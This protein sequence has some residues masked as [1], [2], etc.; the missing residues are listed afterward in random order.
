MGEMYVVGYLSHT[1][2]YHLWICISCI[3]VLFRRKES[4][5]L[6][7][8]KQKGSVP[9]RQVMLWAGFDPA[10]EDFL[11]GLQPTVSKTL[12][13]F[14]RFVKLRTCSLFHRFHFGG[15]HV[16]HRQNMHLHLSFA[17]C[18]TIINTLSLVKST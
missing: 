14:A 16:T 1:A 15:Q 3:Q 18:S 10:G 5:L 4:A 6:E 8:L 9:L 12:S 2:N 11:H 7:W 17:I 13:L